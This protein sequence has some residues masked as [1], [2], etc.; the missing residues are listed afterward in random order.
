MPFVDLL[1]FKNNLTDYICRKKIPKSLKL[2]K[3]SQNPEKNCRDFLTQKSSY[4]SFR[5]IYPLMKKHATSSEAHG[6]SIV[7][8]ISSIFDTNSVLKHL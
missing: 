1:H 4:A 2:G 3:K 5:V 6:V 7:K 8:K